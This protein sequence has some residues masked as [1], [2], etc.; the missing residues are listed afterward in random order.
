MKT[1]S[2]VII[3]SII[4]SVGVAVPSAMALGLGGYYTSGWGEGSVNAENDDNDEWD[5]DT[6][7]ERRGY[8][9]VL[10]TNLAKDRLVNLRVNLA[11]YNY[12]D[13]DRSKNVLELDGGQLGVDL[14]F[15]FIR[16]KHMRIWVGPE[17]T[18]SYAE[19]GIEENDDW[20]YYF[21]N[22]G[23]GPVLGANFHLGDRISLGLKVG[24]LYEQFI[25]KAEND[26]L[27]SKIDYDG[28]TTQYLVNLSIFY[29]F[30]DKF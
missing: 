6:D 23:L 16:N 10:D 5:F 7:F 14:G 22:V 20:D 19:G 1:L 21:I 4:L 12:Q 30:G 27:D 29:R 24:W 13:Q 9:L 26:D 25:G 17:M 2:R 8:G 15:G 3:L 11:N 18:I 28:Y